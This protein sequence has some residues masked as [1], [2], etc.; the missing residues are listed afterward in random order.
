LPGIAVGNEE[1][2]ELTIQQSTPPSSSLLIFESLPNQVKNAKFCAHVSYQ[3]LRINCKVVYSMCT[4]FFFLLKQNEEDRSLSG[5]QTNSSLGEGAIPRISES[6]DIVVVAQVQ[7][8][9]Y[10]PIVFQ[11][12][13]FLQMKI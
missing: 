13:Y 10:S 1:P 9:F 11:N 6:H 12:A 3:G 7:V 4:L 8:R 5:D 2:N